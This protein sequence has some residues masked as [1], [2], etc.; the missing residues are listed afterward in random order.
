M[1]ADMALARAQQLPPPS[2]LPEAWEVLQEAAG[3]KGPEV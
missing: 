3:W 2:A 1:V